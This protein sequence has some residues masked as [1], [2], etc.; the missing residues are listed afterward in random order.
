MPFAP[1]GRSLSRN[2]RLP[3]T[4]T[5]PNVQLTNVQL[6]HSLGSTLGP[7]LLL[8]RFLD[9]VVALEVEAEQVEALHHVRR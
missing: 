9:R 7:A 2:A 8:W 1:A 4:C 3:N 5:C 6:E